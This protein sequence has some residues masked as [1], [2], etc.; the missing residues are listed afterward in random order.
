LNCSWSAAEQEQFNDWLKNEYVAKVLLHHPKHR[1]RRGSGGAMDE[2]VDYEETRRALL[3]VPPTTMEE[4]N[5]F[6]EALQSYDTAEMWLLEHQ[7]TTTAAADD[8]DAKSSSS[9]V[10]AESPSAKSLPAVARQWLPLAFWQQL[11]R[12]EQVE[13]LLNLG[14]LRPILDEYYPDDQRQAFMQ[15]YGHLLFQEVPLEHLVPDPEGPLD[16][17]SNDWPAHIP[18]PEATATDLGRYRLETQPYLADGVADDLLD[19]WNEH[20][21][22][23]AKYEERLFRTERLGLRYRDHMPATDA[24][25]LAQ[26]EQS[27][28]PPEQQTSP[29]P[30]AL[31]PKAPPAP[32]KSSSSSSYKGRTGTVNQPRKDSRQPASGGGGGAKK[33]TTR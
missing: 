24:E 30:P 28:K 19:V 10:T 7:P 15:H 12:T 17:T 31:A 11:S 4:S 26:Y 18:K 2:K 32:T 1:H 14:A 22:N 20:K 9:V 21:A 33:K 13:R 23:R 25:W 29:S 27:L 6:W 5:A 8:D 16:V 3:S